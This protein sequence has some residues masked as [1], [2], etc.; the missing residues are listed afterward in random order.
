MVQRYLRQLLDFISNRLPST[1][2]SLSW[3]VWVAQCEAEC[4]HWQP[5]FI[6]MQIIS[7][8]NIMHSRIIFSLCFDS[9]F[10]TIILKKFQRDDTLYSTLWFPGSRSTCFG[11]NP[12]PS[13]GAQLNCIHSIWGWQTVC[14][15]PSSWM[16][17]NLLEYP[18]SSSNVILLLK[19]S[20]QTST[21]NNYK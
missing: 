11:R 9:K 2:P 12:R 17:Q 3:G 7:F 18:F 5:T 15:Q 6:K 21:D 4:L 1:V 13:S 19:S 14:V 20:P 16:S 8:W 10:W